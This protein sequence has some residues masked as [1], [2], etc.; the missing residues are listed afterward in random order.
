MDFAKE[1]K[2]G[3]GLTILFMVTVSV[4]IFKRDQKTVT[5]VTLSGTATSFSKIDVAKHNNRN[6]C[7][8]VIG[9]NVYN[10]TAY[11]SSHPGGAN[12]IIPYCG[13]DATNVFG[14]VGKHESTKATKDL[15]NLLIGSFK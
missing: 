8:I 9:N 15:S 12:E 5:P 6:D 2:I 11:L 7:W 10:T 4:L 13:G 1:L 3:I 14:S